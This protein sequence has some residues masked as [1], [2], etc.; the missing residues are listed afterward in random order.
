MGKQLSLDVQDTE[1]DKME[2][3]FEKMDE[4]TTNRSSTLTQAVFLQNAYTQAG[5]YLVSLMKDLNETEAKEL[6]E[7]LNNSIEQ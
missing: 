2:I 4:E 1:I 7:E 3:D 5:P 6:L